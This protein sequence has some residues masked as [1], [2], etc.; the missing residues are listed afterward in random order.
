MPE[1]VVKRGFENPAEAQSLKNSITGA[2]MGIV[3]TRAP[4]VPE[5]YHSIKNDHLTMS[6]DPVPYGNPRLVDYEVELTDKVARRL[7]NSSIIKPGDVVTIKPNISSDGII[8]AA[9]AGFKVGKNTHIIRGVPIP[10]A[11]I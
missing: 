8:E 6:T 11:Q 4:G 10:P 9:M 2:L 5:F 7:R 1:I 3:P